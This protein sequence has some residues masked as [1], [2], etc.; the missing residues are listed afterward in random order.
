MVGRSTRSS[1][2]GLATLASTPRRRPGAPRS[3][4]RQLGDAAQHGVGALLGLDRQHQAV[5]DDRALADV[6]R[7]DRAGDLDRLGDVG[8]VRRVRRM[9]AER[10]G[11]QGQ[12]AHHLVGA[13]DREAF[14]LELAHQEAQQR[15]VALARGHDGAGQPGQAAQVGLQRREIRPPDDAGEAQRLAAGVSASRTMRADLGDAGDLARMRVQRRIGEALQA[16][17]EIGPPGSPAVLGERRAADRRRPRSAPACA[18]RGP[19][20]C[21]AAGIS[22]RVGSARMKSTISITCGESAICLGGDSY[23]IGELI[24]ARRRSARKAARSVLIWSREK[25]RRF[26]P[27][28]FRPSSLA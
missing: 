26:R 17:D 25:P 2:I 28:R 9:G 19:Q 18:W 14:L 6:Q 3:V 1:W 11:R 27:T 15:V 13:L 22:G 7:A 10:P 12:L 21:P 5:A 20:A 16:D 4:G 23:A 8:G 24:G